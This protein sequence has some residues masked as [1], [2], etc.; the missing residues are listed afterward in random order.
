MHQLFKAREK[1]TPEIVELLNSVTLGTNGAHYRHLDTNERIKELD[2]PLFLTIERNNQIL[3]N[4]TF[5]RRGNQW[6]V[7]YFAFST[8][9]QSKGAKKSKG[10]SLLK[11]ELNSYF[12]TILDGSNEHGKADSLYAYIDP[13][14]EKSLWMSENFNFKTIGKV[15]TQ[16]FSRV[17]P[18]NSSRVRKSEDWNKI[19]GLVEAQFGDYQNFFTSQTSKAPFY[20][21]ENEK[22]ELIA[23]AKTTISTW[24]IKRMPGKIGGVLTKVVP[25]I[26][27]L[28][29]LIRPKRHSFVVPEAVFVKDNDSIVLTELFEAI[30]FRENKNLILWWVDEKEGLYTSVESNVK[31]GLLHKLVGV[32]QV[33]I[34][35]RSNSE[36]NSRAPFYTS[37]FDFI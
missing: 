6:Y 16:T 33:N 23:F 17:N 21:I 29:K 30:L 12:Q 18:K 11:E 7:R 8:K 10:R 37:G 3:G 1:E 36:S 4:S 28:N 31:W 20:T 14:N 22:G 13:N 24:E 27:R 34:V 9:F 26:P 25:F 5:C 35:Q 19:K 32:N 2:A 15:A